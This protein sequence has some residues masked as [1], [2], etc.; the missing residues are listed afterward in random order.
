MILKRQ[1][2]SRRKTGTYLHTD[3]CVY[4]ETNKAYNFIHKYNAF[5]LYIKTDH[6][7]TSPNHN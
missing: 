1:I 5:T 3:W 7:I 4:E 6:G 2:K